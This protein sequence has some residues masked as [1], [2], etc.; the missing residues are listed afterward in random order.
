MS[1]CP[2]LIRD[3]ER[4][5]GENTA[6]T[7]LTVGELLR[8]AEL[9][10]INFGDENLPRDEVDYRKGQSHTPHS[11]EPFESTPICISHTLDP[12][13]STVIICKGMGVTDQKTAAS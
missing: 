12:E 9:D 11:H 7:T 8:G 4:T 3:S 2:L 6:I 1:T 10:I 5:K 13:R